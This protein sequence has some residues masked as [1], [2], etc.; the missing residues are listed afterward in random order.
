[1]SSMSDRALVWAP[2]ALCFTF[3]AFISLFALDAIDSSHS[4][5]TNAM[6]LVVH[7]I[8]TWVLLAFLAVG[9]RWPR[10]G[11]VLLIAAGLYYALQ[12][13]PAHHLSWILVVAA[14][15]WLCGAL[16]LISA[17]VLHKRHFAT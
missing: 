12:S 11:G 15:A 2:R 9:W 4:F 10:A 14:P 16:F 5:R 7:L 6:D 3:A 8:P 1:M 17:R 13:G